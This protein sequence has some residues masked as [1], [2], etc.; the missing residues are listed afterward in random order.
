MLLDEKLPRHIL[1]LLFIFIGMKSTR[2]FFQTLRASTTSSFSF[3]RAS[4]FANSLKEITSDQNQMYK[5]CKVL[6]NK[7]SKRK[8]EQLM[9]LESHRTIIEG[10]KAGLVPTTIF[11]TSSSLQAPLAGVLEEVI[12]DNKY[13][14]IT[15]YTKESLV[16]KISGLLDTYIVF[17]SPL[18]FS[19]L[20]FS[21]I[22]N[23]ASNNPK[24]SLIYRR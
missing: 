24:I 23:A 21:S 18:L 20:L 3:S 6:Y 8:E 12:T 16:R 19:S 9:I 2:P 5:F 11:A 13:T 14:D 15:Y 22:K 1:F 17:F 7:K 4:A 10:I